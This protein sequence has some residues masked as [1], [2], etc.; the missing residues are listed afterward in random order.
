M[1]DICGP[2]API[3]LEISTQNFNAVA[4]AL[5]WYLCQSG[6]RYMYIEHY[7]DYFTIVDP[8]NSQHC[9]ED[10]DT[11]KAVCEE[12]GVP[13]ASHKQD[14]PLTHLLF[15]RIELDTVA[16]ELCLPTDKLSH[17][18]SPLQEWELKKVCTRK[19]LESLIGLLNHAYKVVRSGRP[20]LR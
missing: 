2:N 3:W 1:E 4:D 16:G 5:I 10:L 9:T 13:L 6:I 8:P 7:L 19:E 20:F 14:G 15:L 11:L 17:L 18:Q 12:L